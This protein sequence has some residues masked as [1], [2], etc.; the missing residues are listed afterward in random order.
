MTQRVKQSKIIVIIRGIEASMADPLF[1]ALYEGGIRFAEVTLNTPDALNI[2][3]AMR[4]K[5][6]GRMS[7]GAGT[8]LNARMAHEA[9]QAGAEFLISP[10]VDQGM[11]EAALSRGVLPMPGAMTPTEIVQAIHYGAP[12]AKVFPCSSLGPGYIKELRGPL[13]HID[14]LAVGG[15]TKENAAAF[16]EAGAIGVGV[17]GSLVSLHDIQQGHYAAI[18][19]YAKQLV[20]AV[21]ETSSTRGDF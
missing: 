6:E 13:G 7:V 12:M 18:A 3:H 21:N 5:Y 11:I 19:Q 8:V 10:N 1:E 2:I 9:M 20:A 4:D 16:L 15:V 14:M 17:G